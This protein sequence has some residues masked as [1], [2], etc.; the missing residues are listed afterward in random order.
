MEP[1]NVSQ[2][3]IRT[4]FDGMYYTRGL[5]YLRPRESYPVFLQLLHTQAGGRLLDVACGP[6]LLLHE[7][8]RQGVGAY[9]VDISAVAI[10]MAPQVALG[11]N[12]VVG[13]AE[14]LPFADHCFD[15][16]TCIGA[17]ERF[18]DRATA[19]REMQRVAAPQARFCVM[20]RNA[21]SL[22]WKLLIELWHR[23]NYTGHQDADTLES[24]SALFQQAE[25]CIDDI[26][27][28]QWLWQRLRRRI[29]RLLQPR[30]SGV[31]RPP[32]PLRFANEFIFLLRLRT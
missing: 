7:A 2:Q 21:L 23:R 25:F 17:L 11:A 10:A 4:W 26:V 22:K 29:P 12:T 28:D 8:Q 1:Q 14:H 31:T 27:P 3:A 24:W 6:G 5:Q 19:L 16:V 32:L 15:Y 9:G 20:V 30:Y 18:L 13:N